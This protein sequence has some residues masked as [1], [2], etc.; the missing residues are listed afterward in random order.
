M[1]KNYEIV[2]LYLIK[3]CDQITEK[4]YRKF[5]KKVIA[6]VRGFVTTDSV[7]EDDDST[8]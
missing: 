3:F 2:L 1:D 8:K 6:I 5:F 7:K 4:K